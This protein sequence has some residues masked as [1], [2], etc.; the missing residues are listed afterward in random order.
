M[1]DKTHAQ[2][3]LTVEMLYEVLDQLPTPIYIKDSNLC[4]VFSNRAH[5][6]MVGKTAAEFVG[7]SDQDIHPAQLAKEF[8]AK[9]H[10]VLDND[11]P[12]VVDEEVRYPDGHLHQILTRKAKYVAPDGRS[13]LIGTNS[14]V[15]LLKKREAQN[16]AITESIP[17]GVMQV[18]EN[19]R[20][21][22]CNQLLYSY[23]NR[24]PSNISIE[25]ICATVG[26]SE[27]E[28]P[29]LNSRF[30]CEIVDSGGNKRR[31][32]FISSGW[33]KLSSSATRSAIVSVVDVSENVELKRIND[34]IVR[35][36]NDLA[37]NVRLLHDAQDALVRKGRLEQMGQLTA[38]IAHELRNPLGA[39]RTSAFVMER[40]LRDSPVDL[41]AQ[42]LRI[43]N[44]VT[45]CDNI[46]AQLLD[47]ARGKQLDCKLM[48]FDE[49]LSR[50]LEEEVA[51]MPAS[52]NVQ[53]LLGLGDTRMC[54][55]PG[56]LQRAIIN[57]LANA[58][59]AMVGADGNE[60]LP[61]SRQAQISIST[62]LDGASVGISVIDNGPGMSPEVVERIREPLFTTKSFGTGLGVP[63]IEQIVTQHG[64]TLEIAS[65]PG[66]GSSFTLRLPIYEEQA[67]SQTA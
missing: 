61:D 19:G 58:S 4:F 5:C 10:A 9:D 8:M 36:N 53:C 40:R 6:D 66:V 60:K 33:L 50:I 57:L 25:Y 34:E 39:I 41:D 14:D 62:F 38:T 45:R 22:S 55:D 54:F 23:M 26:K 64:G 56:R 67:L 24:E 43:K 20:I 27:T 49:W 1:T 51:R 63:V 17:V 30:E 11:R 3:Q 18:D 44:G 31:L 59:E 15:T 47:F 29:G 46:I 35:L 21:S 37:E 65:E 28:F 48:N 32:L 16:R 13:F 7:L 42:F 12:L 2:T 52:V